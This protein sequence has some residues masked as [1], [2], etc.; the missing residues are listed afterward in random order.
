VILISYLGWVAAQITA[1]GLVFTL[2][3]GGAVSVVKA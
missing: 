3:S 1:L 2:L